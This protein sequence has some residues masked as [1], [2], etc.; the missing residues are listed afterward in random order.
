MAHLK[1]ECIPR[2]KFNF[3]I[4]MTERSIRMHS[5]VVPIQNFECTRFCCLKYTLIFGVQYGPMWTIRNML[6]NSLPS[7]PL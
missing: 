6:N 7:A 4:Q 1:W 3:F 5:H 2:A